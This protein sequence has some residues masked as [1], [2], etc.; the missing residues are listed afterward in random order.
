MDVSVQPVKV[1]REPPPREEA[2]V[3][4]NSA[5]SLGK[6]ELCVVSL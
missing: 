1:K 5:L 3:T 4:L 6:A 2:G